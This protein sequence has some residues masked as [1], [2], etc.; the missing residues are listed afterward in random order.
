MAWEPP[1]GSDPA[2]VVEQLARDILAVFTEVEARLLGDIARRARAG[3]DVPE[4][5]TQKAAAVREMRLAVERLITQLRAEVGT[6]AAE[7]VLAAWQAGSAA[8]LA[9]L[10]DLGAL[11]EPQL[12]ALREVIPGMDAAALLAADLTSRLDALYLRVLRWGQDA[13]QVAVAAAAPAQLLGTGTTRSAQR[14]AWD[15]LVSQGVSGFVDRSGRPWNLATYVEMATRTATARAWNEGHLARLDSLGVDLVTVSNTTD[16]CA[17]CS[18]WQGR[19]LVRTGT[20]GAR[21]VENELTG[22][23]MRVEVAGSVDEA[24]AAGLMHP[25]CR[26]TFVPFIPGV[27]RLDEPVEHDQ[28][29]EDEREHLRELERKVRKEKRKEAGALDDTTRRAAQQRIRGLQAD[30]REHV[31]ATGLNR[32]RYREQLDL[33]HGTISAARARRAALADQVADGTGEQARLDAVAAEQAQ[34]RERERLAAEQAERQRVEREQAEAQQAERDRAARVAAEL[35]AL[36]DEELDARFVEVSD[37][38]SA[39]DAVLDE[40]NR[41]QAEADRVAERREQ[42]R[43]RREQQ[44][45]ERDAA[46]WARFEELIDEGW[47]DEEAAA[48]AYGHSVE[49]QRRDRA[50]AQLRGQ[51]YTG[52]GFD[53][54]A[55]KAFRDHVYEQYIAAEDATRGHMVTP[56]GQ[57]AGIDPHA[58]FTGPESRARKWASDELKEWWDTHGRITYDEWTARLLGENPGQGTT[59]DGWL[60]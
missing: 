47:S 11:D 35:A 17:L 58:L 14:A 12:V 34:R 2:E 49:R 1:P 24:R 33:G 21:T 13:Y 51:G 56:A 37:D 29:A 8:A 5:A 27:T 45:A 54:L 59:G 16:G 3:A 28:A 4:W 30:I 22:T 42:D 9:Q 32:K 10:A 38:E 40:M 46:Q 57:A 18:V 55:R 26:H 19:I 60:R 48:E 15:R 50:I 25:N 23:P 31:D 43:A 52:R 53:E 20:G 36:S 44:R 41:R 39:I 7:A 6:S